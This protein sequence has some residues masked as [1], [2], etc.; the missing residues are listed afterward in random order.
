MLRS[1]LETKRGDESVEVVNDPVAVF[2]VI[3]QKIFRLMFMAIYPRLDYRE[4]AKE[5]KHI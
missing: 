2:V 4:K 3:I 1:P 5:I